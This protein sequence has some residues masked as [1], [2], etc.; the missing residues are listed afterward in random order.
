[1]S[2]AGGT[3]CVSVGSQMKTPGGNEEVYVEFNDTG[4]GMA[5]EVQGRIFDPFFTTKATGTGL[6]LSICHE[7]VQAHGGKIEIA[8]AQACGTTVRVSLPADQKAV[9]GHVA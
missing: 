2:P 3:L 6:G 7:L 9:A 4:E 1:M 8:S 5:A